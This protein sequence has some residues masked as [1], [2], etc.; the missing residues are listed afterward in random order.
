MLC[1]SAIIN[2]DIVIIVISVTI[3]LK[4]G[5]AFCNFCRTDPVKMTMN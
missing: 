1:N 2:V 5:K 3:L 4:N